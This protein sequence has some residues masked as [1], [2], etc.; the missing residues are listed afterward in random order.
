M[1]PKTKDAQAVKA[2][3]LLAAVATAPA[4]Q[5]EFSIKKGSIP[6][7]SDVDA[8]RMDVCAQKGIAIMRDKSRHLANGEVFLTPDQNG[9]LA[10]IVTAYWNRNTPVEK[11]QKDIAAALAN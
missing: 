4:T 7:R 3:K 11:V 5:V 6:V 10:D 1:F 8:S 2:Q 9:A